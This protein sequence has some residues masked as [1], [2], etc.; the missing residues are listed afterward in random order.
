MIELIHKLPGC[1]HQLF[2]H[3][4]QNTG[5][6]LILHPWQ[7]LRVPHSTWSEIGILLQEV[8]TMGSAGDPGCGQGSQESPLYNLACN[9]VLQLGDPQVRRDG[10]PCRSG[11]T[12]TRF[13]IQTLDCLFYL[14]S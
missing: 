12:N 14:Y 7:S 5:Y 9:L 2:S 8:G 4:S 3:S 10:V 11:T 13:S 1:S 6:R